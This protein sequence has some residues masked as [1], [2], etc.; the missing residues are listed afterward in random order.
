MITPLWPYP[1]AMIKV[2]QRRIVVIAD[3]HIGWE[4]SLSGKGIHVPTQTP[5]L[6][7]RLKELL[8]R[9]KPE[10]LLILGDVKHTVATAEVSEWHDVPD[11]FVEL[12][13]LVQK[14]RVIRGNH[15]GNLEPLLPENIELLPATGIILGKVGLFHGHQW[16]SADVLTCKT[17]VMGHVHPVVSLRDPA[18]FRIMRQVWIKAL[19]DR[20][21]LARTMMQRHKLQS[22]LGNESG[23]CQTGPKVLQLFIMPSFNEFL[24]GRPLNERR[25][26]TGTEA[27][28]AV[29]PILHSEAVDMD[30]A[31]TYLLDGNF[32]GT[33]S[34]L[35]M[36]S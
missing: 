3:L 10:E 11:F 9:Y 32:L 27:K 1:A 17:I 14:V 4:M 31:E 21:Q 33:L 36:L 8:S 24:G 5:K 2:R 20:E 29:G 16:P 7:G 35:R 22:T 12:R 26:G 23:H 25:I 30:R 28:V 18:G 34:D 13:K 6:M 19:C 15:D